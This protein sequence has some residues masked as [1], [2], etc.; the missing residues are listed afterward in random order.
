MIGVLITGV[1]IGLCVGIIPLYI[2]Y[3]S[4]RT[5]ENNVKE[6]NLDLKDTLDEVG[7]RT[8]NDNEYKISTENPDKLENQ[9]VEFS[10]QKI[11]NENIVGVNKEISIK[12]VSIKPEEFTIIYE[13]S[14]S[15]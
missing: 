14:G 10:K 15:P 2:S 5:L 4:Q 7:T 13:I 12:K 11:R 6:I 8:L 1:I 9:V 3:N